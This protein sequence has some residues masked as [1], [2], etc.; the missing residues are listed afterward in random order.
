MYN[1][2][3]MYSHNLLILMIRKLLLVVTS[4]NIITM[5][6]TII[7]SNSTYNMWYLSIVNY[8]KLYVPVLVLK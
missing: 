5:F 2:E 3:E 4:V 1:I 7:Y 6:F 8:T